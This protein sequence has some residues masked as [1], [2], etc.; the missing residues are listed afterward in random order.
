MSDIGFLTFKRFCKYRPDSISNIAFRGKTTH[1]VNLCGFYS[2]M[3]ADLKSCLYKN[4]PAF[5]HT[6]KED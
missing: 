1:N 5:M 2:I 3:K 6:R 4:C